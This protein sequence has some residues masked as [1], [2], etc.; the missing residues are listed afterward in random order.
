MPDPKPKRIFRITYSGDPKFPYSLIDE[1][2]TVRMLSASL[3]D[4]GG[5][6][7]EVGADEVRHECLER[8]TP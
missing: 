4:L 5:W 8:G 1:T 3:L 6:A 2:D 7:F